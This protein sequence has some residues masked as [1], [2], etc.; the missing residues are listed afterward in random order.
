M[1]SSGSPAW[2]AF[3]PLTV[4]NAKTRYVAGEF[5]VAL[6][7]IALLIAVYFWKRRD[8]V[9]VGAARA[10]AGALA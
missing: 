4:D 2:A 8:E 1:R 3:R 7:V 10:T 5:G 9:A 6:G